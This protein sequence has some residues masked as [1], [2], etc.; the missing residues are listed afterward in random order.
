MCR[1]QRLVSLA[2]AVV[3]HVAGMPGPV[4]GFTLPAGQCRALPGTRGRAHPRCPRMMD[5]EAEAEPVRR[6]PVASD[7]PKKVAP[8]FPLPAQFARCP[9]PAGN[10]GNHARAQASTFLLRWRLV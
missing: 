1:D 4:S 9:C 2:L 7:G 6:A 10:I 3:I 5:N 8:P